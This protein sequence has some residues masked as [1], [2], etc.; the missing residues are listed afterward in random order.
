MKQNVVVITGASSGMGKAAAELF[1]TKGWL[2][3][4][5]A[6]HSEN[7]PT[8]NNIQA[9]HLDV[10]SE[11]SVENFMNLI[12][13]RTD[14]VD[15]LINAVGYGEYGPIEEVPLSAIKTEFSTNFFGAIRMTQA[16]LPSMRTNKSGRIINVSSGIGTSYMPTGGYYAASKAALQIWSDTL[17]IE[18]QP[19]GIQSTIVSPGATKTN[20]ISKMFASFERNTHPTSVYTSLMAGVA[21][22]SKNYKASATAEDLASVFYRAATALRPKMRYY[23]SVSDRMN[24]YIAR[25]HPL[26]WKC[27]MSRVTKRMM[28]VSTDNNEES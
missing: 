7:I 25:N 14:H 28:R 5:G 13:E 4:G 10:T 6:R 16:I 23:K 24:V 21:N 19:F 15:V 12:W 2:V 27:L 18:V 20:F 1:A 9:L 17:N 26:I 22:M 11:E 8:I 3:F